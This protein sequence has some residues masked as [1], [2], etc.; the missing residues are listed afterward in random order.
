MWINCVKG[1]QRIQR[2]CDTLNGSAD[3][4]HQFP[5]RRMRCVLVVRFLVVGIMM[6]AF[7]ILLSS[8]CVWRW[9][10][11]WQENSWPQDKHY[12]QISTEPT[13]PDGDM[14]RNKI[15][16]HRLLVDKAR[17]YFKCIESFVNIS[18]IV[19][20]VWFCYIR[21]PF[22][23]LQLFQVFQCTRSQTMWT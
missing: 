19:L 21:F 13:N 23:H 20:Q 4:Y 22:T 7:L 6:I 3:V 9:S 5:I 18:A 16:I 14:I 8:V 12:V 1:R 17:C 10:A 2:H 11:S 15:S